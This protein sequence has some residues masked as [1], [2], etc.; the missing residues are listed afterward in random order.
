VEKIL[1]Q[2]EKSKKYDP[3]HFKLYTIKNYKNITK[4]IYATKILKPLNPHKNGNMKLTFKNS[5][6]KHTNLNSIK[7]SGS[8]NQSSITSSQ[9][10]YL[11]ENKSTN[12]TETDYD[13]GISCNQT[14]NAKINNETGINSTVLNQSNINS[15]NQTAF[16]G[17]VMNETCFN[18]TCNETANNNFKAI[19]EDPE[20]ST[21]NKVTDTLLAI[22]YASTAIAALCAMNPEPLASKIICAVAV[23]VAVISFVAVI[24]C[25]WLW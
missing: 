20:E 16:N 25:K 1:P 21:K 22:G 3:K 14:C 6:K 24:F 11:I 2:F 10:E 8:T 9:R 19:H 18:N 7:K 17:T 12:S 15:T 23:T 4:K 13:T 5:S